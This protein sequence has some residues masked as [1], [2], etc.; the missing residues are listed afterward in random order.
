MR[1]I[2]PLRKVGLIKEARISKNAGFN[3]CSKTTC[4]TPIDASITWIDRAM[5]TMED[6]DDENSHEDE[7]AGVNECEVEGKWKKFEESYCETAR[8]VL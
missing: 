1:L 4:W 7:G 5:K 8:D 6:E 3:G 2:T